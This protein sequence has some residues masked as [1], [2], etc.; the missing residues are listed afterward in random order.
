MI[1]ESVSTPVASNHTE[2]G[3]VLYISDTP[4]NLLTLLTHQ[5][6]KSDL[7]DMLGLMDCML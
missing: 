7:F 3:T 4:T 6:M 5:H 2:N 1:E